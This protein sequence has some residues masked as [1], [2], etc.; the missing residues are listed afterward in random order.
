M[1]SNALLMTPDVNAS[2]DTPIESLLQ[3]PSRRTTQEFNRLRHS[4]ATPE[5]RELY[6]NPEHT[7][8]NS[9]HELQRYRESNAQQNR[10]ASN[11]VFNWTMGNQ[12]IGRDTQR[13]KRKRIATRDEENIS[14]NK[15]N[16][17]AEFRD[18]SERDRNRRRFLA[19]EELRLDEQERER[20][21]D[22]LRQET[23]A[24]RYRQ[25]M[26]STNDTPGQDAKFREMFGSGYGED[27]TH[28]NWTFAF[29]PASEPSL[30][31][32]VAPM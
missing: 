12:S 13:Q 4:Y 10:S 21:R 28:A 5:L 26:A 1:Y 2:R 25:Y 6:T 3:R 17:R 19:E 11:L 14:G 16:I 15:R 24:E 30:F 7:I 22:E 23:S 9:R 31:H 8:T 29:D 32:I 18:R 27:D 20:Q